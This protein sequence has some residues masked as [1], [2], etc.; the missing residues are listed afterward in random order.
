MCICKCLSCSRQQ[1]LCPRLDGGGGIL[2]EVPRG[3]GK[4]DGVAL[5]TGYG[6]FPTAGNTYTGQIT[7][8]NIFL[9]SVFLR[10][11]FRGCTNIDTKV[12]SPS[13]DLQESCRLVHACC[14]R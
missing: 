7:H 1:L 4:G 3:V 11:A 6:Y 14:S 12:L 9:K 8:E 13:T 5:E 2:E 10:Y